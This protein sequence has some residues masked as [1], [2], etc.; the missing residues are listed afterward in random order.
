MRIERTTSTRVAGQHHI[1]FGRWTGFRRSR[2]TFCCALTRAAAFRMRWVAIATSDSLRGV[3]KG[4]TED[5]A[6]SV[7]AFLVSLEVSHAPFY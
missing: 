3:C 5:G 1:Y 4:G 7:L 6:S 2:A